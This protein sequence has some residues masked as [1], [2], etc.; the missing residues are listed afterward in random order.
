MRKVQH[1]DAE[2]TVF[3]ASAIGISRPDGNQR[4][5]RFFWKMDEPLSF[6]KNG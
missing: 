1:G 4:E 2:S 6:A 5:F 3:S